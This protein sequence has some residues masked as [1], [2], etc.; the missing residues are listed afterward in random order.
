MI[1]VSIILL[2]VKSYGQKIEKDNSS[3]NVCYCNNY[4]IPFYRI[5]Y[6]YAKL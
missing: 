4:N 3:F 1:P 2:A 6:T 5:I